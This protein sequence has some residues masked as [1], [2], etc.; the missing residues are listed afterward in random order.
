MDEPFVSIII[1]ARNAEHTIVPCLRSLRA[2]DYPAD[3]MEIIVVDDGSSDRTAELAE[4][5]GVRLIR[6]V[7]R[8]PG[9]ARNRGVAEARGEFVAFTDA[10]CLVGEDWLRQLLAVFEED[11]A[12]VGG[13][14][15]LANAGYVPRSV[16]SFLRLMGFWGGYTKTAETP[17]PVGHNP[18][19]NV[20]YRKAAFERVGGFNPDLFPGEDVEL[21]ARLR[22]LGSRLLYNPRAVVL[23]YRGGLRAFARMMFRYG[24]SGGCL[25]ARFGLFRPLYLTP[26]L[27]LAAGAVVVALCV[28]LRSL[29][30]LPIA[31]SLP[32]LVFLVVDTP[33]ALPLTLLFW[34]TM[35][36]WNVGFL[37]GLL[38]RTCAPR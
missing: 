37:V 8:G 31:L 19:C 27:T 34:I 30:P 12:A 9:A 24:R 25:L 21:D 18:A 3:R 33:H 20:L 4:S 28:V 17:R 10:D 22:R 35:V 5:E 38:T 1:A 14:Q 15:G 2:L 26:F 29:L 16:H 13:A 7:Q 36:C 23:H 6:A 11:V 32:A